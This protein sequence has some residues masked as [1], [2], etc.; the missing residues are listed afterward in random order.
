[1]ARFFVR[2]GQKTGEPGVSQDKIQ[3]A[4]GPAIGFDDTGR[5]T[6]VGQ[7]EGTIKPHTPTRVSAAQ[8]KALLGAGDAYDA[9][10]FAYEPSFED[11]EIISGASEVWVVRANSAQQG[12]AT[13]KNGSSQDLIDLTSRAYGL[14]ASDISYKVENGTKGALGKKVTISKP[15]L[16]DEVGDDLGFLPAFIVRHKGTVNGTASGSVIRCTMDIS[17]SGLSTETT[18]TGPTTAADL[19]LSFTNFKYLSQLIAEINRDPDY[20]AIA[21]TNQPESFLCSELDLVTDAEIL[22]EGVDD[23]TFAA[24]GTAGTCELRSA[25]GTTPDTQAGVVVKVEDEYLYLATV[26]ANGGAAPDD[27]LVAVRGYLDTNAAAHTTVDVDYAFYPVG[28]VCREVRDWI[29]SFSALLTAEFDASRATGVPANVTTAAAGALSKTTPADPWEGTLTTAADGDW[30]KAYKSLRG[31]DTEFIVDTSGDSTVQTNYLKTH[32]DWRWENNY[33][34]FA[35]CSVGDTTT[36]ATKSA[37]KTRLK[38]LNHARIGVTA[39]NV[40]RLNGDK[41]L[42]T[43]YDAWSYAAIIAGMMAGSTFG[44][45]PA[46]KA[47]YCDEILTDSSI[48]L[49]DDAN[50][51]VA[52]GGIFARYDDG[53]WRTVRALTSWTNDDTHWKIEP[54]VVHS[55]SWSMRDLNRYLHQIFTGASQEP[56]GASVIR[57]TARSRLERQVNLPNAPLVGSQAT[58]PYANLAATLQ[59]NE[60]DLSFDA[61]YKGSLLSGR[62][63]TTVT[64]FSDAA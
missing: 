23:I 34:G 6:V 55:M 25:N 33:N 22:Y 2:A 32:M 52:A 35:L 9:L 48:N 60:W 28:A 46:R 20:E 18:I 21:V 30:D 51:L 38:A 42:S 37:Y 64:E 59:G 63:S 61:T 56:N 24:T 41:T 57:S 8:A 43:E 5:V 44:T 62:V 53:Q 15:G 12:L 58:P 11:R 36:R 39:Q 16:S 3:N 47:I 19:N 4:G 7:C 13:L 49:Y 14:Y 45:D 27:D 54:T 1:M 29:K 17:A 26:T 31:H 10:R 50:E 40:K